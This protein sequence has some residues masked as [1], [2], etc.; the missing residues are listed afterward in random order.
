M[1]RKHSPK[2]S[3]TKQTKVA[4]AKLIEKSQNTPNTRPRVLSSLGG[5]TRVAQCLC[6][7]RFCSRGETFCRQRRIAV[8][9][10]RK[11]FRGARVTDTPSTI[12]TYF[13]PRVGG[14]R[15]IAPILILIAVPLIFAGL[16]IATTHVEI[17]RYLWVAKLLFILSIT[18]GSAIAIFGLLRQRLRG[19]AGEPILVST[20]WYVGGALVA[21]CTIPAF[22]IYKQMLLPM[23]GFPW[24]A[25][26]ASADYFLFLGHDPWRVTHAVFGT[27]AGT[28]FL[29][30]L[31]SLW[32]FIMYGFPALVVA[33]F[34]DSAM[35]VRLIGCW[36]VSWVLIGGIGAWVFASAGPCYYVQLVGP[37]ASFA[38]LSARLAALA[39]AAHASGIKINA[40]DFQPMLLGAYKSSH[41]APAGGISAMPSMHLAMATLFAIAGYQFNRWLGHIMVIYWVLIWIGS[42][43]LGWHYACDGLVAGA[44]MMGIWKLAQRLGVDRSS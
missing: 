22:G 20:I 42:I 44:M 34:H 19:R 14:F 43:H 26:L 38:E 17:A 8:A 23:R 13:W 27:V 10:P 5:A 6:G 7:E 29:D 33:M 36:L 24:D 2:G 12:S 4:Q 18:Y 35:R 39:K 31:Y 32:M 28:K 30:S 15:S 40:I 16:L 41:Y 11:R 3:K 37:N 9:K 21:G 1:K 25:S